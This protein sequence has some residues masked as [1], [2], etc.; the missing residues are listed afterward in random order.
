MNSRIGLPV[1]RRRFHDQWGFGWGM[2]RVQFPLASD[3]KVRR[4]TDDIT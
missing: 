2:I 1:E 4:A 3:S